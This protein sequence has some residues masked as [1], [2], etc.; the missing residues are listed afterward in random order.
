LPL[1]ITGGQFTF[2]LDTDAAPFCAGSYTFELD[3]DSGQKFTS[4]PLQLSIDINDLDTPHINAVALPNTTV[5]APYSDTLTEEGGTAPFTWTVTGLPAGILQHPPG[6]PTL[7][8]T[9]CVAG[10]YPVPASVTDSKSN[11]GSQAFTLQVNK[12][13]TTTGVTSNANPSV[14]QQTVTFTVTVVPQYS[15]VPSGTVTLTDGVSPIASNLPLT[16]GTAT[17][18]T[19]ALSVGVHSITASYAGDANFNSSNSGVWSQTVN[20]A[21]T[22][23]SLSS[24][25]P[26]PMFVGQPITVSYT[27]GVVSPGAGTPIAPLGNI[28]ILA[29]DGSSCTGSAAPSGGMC[30]LLPVPTAAGNVTF[31]ISYPGDTNFVASGFNGSYTVYQLVFTTQPSNTGIGLAIT[32]AVV[33]T[34]EDSS[35]SPLTT[36]TGGITVAI[37]SGP[38]T[39]SGTTTQ[40]AVAG[41]ATFGDLTI[42][43]IANGYTLKASPGG[44]VYDAT[45]NAFNID[46]FY[47]DANG[48]FGTLDLPTGTVTQIGAATVPNST[49]ID[50]TSG[51][52]VYGYNTSGQLLQ[53]TP[54]T[55]AATP[56]GGPGS[57]PDQATTGALTNGSYFGI[58]VVTGNLYS[59]D[60]AAGATTLVGLTSA[61]V[62]PAGCT[63]DSSLTGSAS[64]L[65][66]T[67]GYSGASCTS[68]MADT[69]YQINPADGTTMTGPVTIS[70][71]GVNTFIG[72]TFVGGTLYGFTA[73]GKEY[74]IAPATGVATF[75]TNTT[76]TVSIL[77]AGSSQ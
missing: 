3:L 36:F 34:A 32:P 43:K 5:G 37:G 59:I 26:S 67:I 11:S 44:G 63:L 68:P 42:N 8:G 76:P 7:S 61:P 20:K 40:N 38:G 35:N 62:L 65:Y 72:S 25:M 33:V 55:G 69:L 51:L 21:S 23:T 45:S 75:L 4:S 24:V 16:G 52:Q 60:T 47:V 64:V 39:L 12:A 30:T 49:G 18:T 13:T 73:N 70:G 22:A 6:S 56:V 31:T 48:N 58:D 29:S 57:I 19:S 17:F 53:I 1:P 46:T 28:T 14:F 71:S 15:C 54:S 9:T 77:G 66:Y 2:I 41:V 74:S 27:F 10:S 50:L